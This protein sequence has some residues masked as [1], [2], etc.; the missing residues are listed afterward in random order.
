MSTTSLRST[1]TAAVVIG[2]NCAT[3]LD[4]LATAV[5]QHLGGLGDDLAGHAVTAAAARDGWLHSAVAWGDLVVTDTSGPPSRVCVD[6]SDLAWWTGRLIYADPQWSPSRGRNTAIRSPGELLPHTGAMGR[7]AGAVHAAAETLSRLAET[8]QRGVLAISAAGRLFVPARLLPPEFEIARRFGYGPA[9]SPHV[10]GLLS[11]Y[12][13]AGRESAR[14]A[15]GLAEVAV[16]FGAPTRALAAARALAT[17]PVGPVRPHHR[18]PPPQGP[19]VRLLQE[20]GVV[21]P[22]LLLRAAALDDDLPP[23]IRLERNAG[24]R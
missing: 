1:A 8:E 22:A 7:V 18:D 13:A 6:A 20:Q 14:L 3:A 17:P 5:G 11:A 19:V 4:M 10:E 23:R 15:A 24:P 21:D 16:S 12:Q 2:H 9:Q